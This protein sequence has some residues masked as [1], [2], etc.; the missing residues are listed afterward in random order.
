MRL[1][2]DGR[3][4]QHNTINEHFVDIIDYMY[5]AEAE[6][7]SE[8]EER[9]RIQKS[10]SYK[11]YLKKEEDLRNAAIKAREERNRLLEQ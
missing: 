5:I 6:A 8:L 10:V 4:L 11:E 2:A 3:T 1:S 7:K 9:A